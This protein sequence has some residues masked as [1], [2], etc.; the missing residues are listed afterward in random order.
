MGSYA[1]TGGA[2]GIGGAIV[3]ALEA[4][5]HDVIVV[6]VSPRDVVADLRTTEGREAG[7]AAIRARAPQGLEGFIPC[8]GIGGHFPRASDI[9]RLNFFGVVRMVEALEDLLLPGYGGIVLIA[10]EA[11]FRKGFDADYLEAL[12]AGDEAAAC[13]VIDGMDPAA[14]GFTAYGGGKS[15]LVRWMRHRTASLAKRGLRINAIAP[16]Y[17]VTKMT[18]ETQQSAFAEALEK[19]VKSIPLG[20]MGLPEDMAHA[21]MYLLS[22]RASFVTGSTL[23][24]DGGHDAVKRPDRVA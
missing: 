5:G 11:A 23:H 8:A 1:V 15:G 3:E 7:V 10:S 24:V 12:Y 19:F 22:E 18:E 13:A 16:G 20:R 21:V 6:D 9:V 14:A 4:Q 2:T 17:T